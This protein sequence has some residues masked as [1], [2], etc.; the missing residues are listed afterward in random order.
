MLRVV[1]MALELLGWSLAVFFVVLLLTGPRVVAED[2]AALSSAESAGAAPYAG[3]AGADA[4]ESDGADGKVVFTDTCGGCHTLSAADTSGSI[5]PN[6]DDTALDAGGIER[7]VRDGS[8]EMPAFAGRLS[9]E[10]IAAVA[11]FVASN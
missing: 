11:N 6:L 9:D 7:I 1:D 4:E 3:Q 2:N 8:G 5:G 10:E